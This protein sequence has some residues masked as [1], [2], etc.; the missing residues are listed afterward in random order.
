V[1]TTLQ[2][3]I[4]AAGGVL[5]GLFLALPV[6]ICGWRRIRDLR[7]QARTDDLTGLPNRRALTEHLHRAERGGGRYGVVLLDLDWFKKVND[8]FTHQA[9][10]DLLREVAVRLRLAAALNPTVRCVARLG[11]DEFV[12]VVDGDVEDAV[13]AAHAARQEISAESI[14]V[15]PS[16]YYIPIRAS[17]GCAQSAPDLS[18]NQVLHLADRAMY[19][20][21]HTG[22][23]HAHRIADEEPT[24]E[25][26]EV[27]ARPNPRIRDTRNPAT[28][29]PG[30]QP[31]PQHAATP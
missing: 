9:G 11:G 22:A 30:K 23:V 19:E 10:D 26:T 25:P 8:Y 1:S 16:G 27:A 7:R 28:P 24:E 4:T 15:R 31:P 14:R 12:I 18:P 2:S 3:L 20:S 29:D 13:A 5:A 6:L 21:K 17:A